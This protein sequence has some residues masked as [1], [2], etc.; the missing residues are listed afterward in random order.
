ME[1]YVCEHELDKE[2]SHMQIHISSNLVISK[3]PKQNTFAGGVQLS[4][5]VAVSGA[6]LGFAGLK[7]SILFGTHMP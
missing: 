2:C 1:K 4:L 7:H 3:R 6:A 5:S